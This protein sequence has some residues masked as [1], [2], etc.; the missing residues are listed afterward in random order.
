MIEESQ[1]FPFRNNE[2]D[3]LKLKVKL[4]P[5][6]AAIEKHLFANSPS[7]VEALKALKPFGETCKFY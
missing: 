3:V 5:Y 4:S 1:Q 2:R 6:K 7:N